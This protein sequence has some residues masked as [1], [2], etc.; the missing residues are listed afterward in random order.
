VGVSDLLWHKLFVLVGVNSSADEQNSQNAK[1]VQAGTA[2][3]PLA[4]AS[5]IGE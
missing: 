4:E 5:A 2:D 1:D 3:K